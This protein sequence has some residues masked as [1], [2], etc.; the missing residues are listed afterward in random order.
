MK[1][2]ELL[3]LQERIVFLA[4]LKATGSVSALA[5]TLEIHPRTVKRL[6][7]RIR[8]RGIPI[9]YSFARGTYV[10]DD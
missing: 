9:R 2:A 4:R 6:V 7:K 5:G 8:E 1:Q 3:K 10:L